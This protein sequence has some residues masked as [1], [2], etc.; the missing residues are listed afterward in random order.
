MPGIEV[1]RPFHPRCRDEKRGAREECGNLGIPEVRRAAMPFTRF[2]R[3]AAI[4]RDQRKLARDWLLRRE[5]DTQRGAL[6]RRDRRGAA[7]R[8]ALAL[9]S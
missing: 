1:D 5:D 2:G 6:P 7:W 9:L 4:G 3:N 8:D